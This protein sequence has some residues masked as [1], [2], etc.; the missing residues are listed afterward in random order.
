[1]VYVCR[2]RPV[3]PFRYRILPWSPGAKPHVAKCDFPTHAVD[4]AFVDSGTVVEGTYGAFGGGMVPRRAC[5]ISSYLAPGGIFALRAHCALLLD[6]VPPEEP[7]S[8]PLGN[9][10]RIR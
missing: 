3:P 9:A 5:P 10:L 4:E 8:T 2:R 1:M 6:Y 7:P